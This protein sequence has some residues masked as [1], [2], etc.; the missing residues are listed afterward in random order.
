MKFTQPGKEK[1]ETHYAE[2]KGKPFFEKLINFAISGPV[3]A[4]IWEGND[5]IKTSRKMI[6]ETDPQKAAKGTFRGDFGLNMGRNSVHGSDS[7]ESA[8]REIGIWFTP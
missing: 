2:H 1:F 3:C 8:E 5:I 7:T 6:G 4:M